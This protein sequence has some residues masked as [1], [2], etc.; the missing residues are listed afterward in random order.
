MR[1]PLSARRKML[2]AQVLPRLKEPVRE[3]PQLNARLPDI[4]K[5]VREHGFE[6]IV[7]KRLDSRYEPGRRSGVW[8]KMRVNRG[9][10]LVIGG[11]TPSPKSFDALIFGYYEGDKLLYAARTRSGF[12]PASRAELHRRFQALGMPDCPFTD[13][14]EER[15]GRWARGSRL[16][17]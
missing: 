17:R 7:A 8:R 15:G 4:V 2:Q 11:Y 3:S 5:A 6:G 13:S 10:E 14:P 1:E 9:Q 12:A 16:R